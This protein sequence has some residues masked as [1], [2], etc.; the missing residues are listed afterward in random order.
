MVLS[1][2]QG[3]HSVVTLL[4]ADLRI[5]ISVLKIPVRRVVRGTAVVEEVSITG[6]RNRQIVTAGGVSSRDLPRL[7]HIRGSEASKRHRHVGCQDVSG[8]SHDRLTLVLPNLV[9]AFGVTRCWWIVRHKVNGRFEDRRTVSS[10]NFKTIALSTIYQ[11]RKALPLLG[12]TQRIPF[13]PLF[14]RFPIEKLTIPNF[15][16]FEYTRCL[17]VA[18]ANHPATIEVACGCVCV[19]IVHMVFLKN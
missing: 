18:S 8:D 6:G 3:S 4:W 16:R 19:C 1:S 7:V 2:F 13:S 17:C 15:Y 12:V 5:T 9:V 11:D 14:Q 10:V